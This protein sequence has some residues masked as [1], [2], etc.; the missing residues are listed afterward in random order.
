MPVL[1]CALAAHAVAYRSF[2]PGDP[3]HGYLG[4]YEAA[5]AVVSTLALAVVLLPQLLAALGRRDGLARV[6]APRVDPTPTGYR[7]ASIALWA[8]GLLVVQETAEAIVGATQGE[9]LA[10]GFGS[11]LVAVA[12][13]RGRLSSGRLRLALVSPC[14][15]RAARVRPRPACRARQHPCPGPRAPPLPAGG[16]RWPTSARFAHPPSS[17][18]HARRRFGAGERQ[19]EMKWKT[20]QDIAGTTGPVGSVS[21]WP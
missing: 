13:S 9:R 8:Y 14:R 1:L 15:R 2:I 3:V 19:E 6:L 10:F 20:T 18:D 17:P 21:S 7:V 4:I 11:W 16:R 5:V 12:G